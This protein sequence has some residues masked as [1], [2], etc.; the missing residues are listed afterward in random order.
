MY[1]NPAGRWNDISCSQERGYICRMKKTGN[2]MTTPKPDNGPCPPD[3]TLWENACYK[4][5]G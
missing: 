1:Y 2:D 5:V 4:Y 3:Y